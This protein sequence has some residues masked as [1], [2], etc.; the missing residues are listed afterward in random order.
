MVRIH[1]IIDMICWTG[2][3]PREFEFPSPGSLTSSF[4]GLREHPVEQRR[5]PPAQRLQG[6]LA[7]KKQLSRATLGP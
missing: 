6:Y 3:V 4:H 1:F 2:L 7:H 5:L